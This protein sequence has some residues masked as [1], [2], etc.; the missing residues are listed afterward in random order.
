VSGI[1]FKEYD[2][3]ENILVTQENAILSI[4]LA[5]E[6]RKFFDFRITY[7]LIIAERD[8]PRAVLVIA[9]G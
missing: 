3:V 6:R 7:S 2:K 4:W 8:L 5:V 1:L 9:F